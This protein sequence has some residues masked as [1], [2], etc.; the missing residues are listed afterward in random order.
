MVAVRTG[1]PSPMQPMGSFPPMALPAGQTPV[2][3]SV[4]PMPLAGFP[5][6]PV[7]PPMAQQ[8]SNAPRRRRFGDSLEGMLG[9]NMF[10]PQQQMVAPG[11][12]MMRTPMPRP[13][14]MGGAVQYF[15]NGG[16]ANQ[17]A[18]QSMLSAGIGNIGGKAITSGAQSVQD[19]FADASSRRRRRRRKRKARQE[20]ERLAAEQAALAAQQ[21]N[22]NI[23][24]PMESAIGYF[25]SSAASSPAAPPPPSTDITPEVFIPEVDAASTAE[26]FMNIEKP[27]RILDRQ[28]ALFPDL[29]DDDPAFTQG[30]VPSEVSPGPQFT[31]QNIGGIGLGD[32]VDITNPDYP[33]PM[34]PIP[35]NYYGGSTFEESEGMKSRILYPPSYQQRLSQTGEPS[36]EELEA[37]RA[38][39]YKLPQGPFGGPISP[40]RDD[41]FEQNTFAPEFPALPGNRG[42]TPSGT[43][44]APEA[45]T[46]F[47]ITPEEQ[48]IMSGMSAVPDAGRKIIGEKDDSFAES[49]FDAKPTIEEQTIID[50]MSAVPG[51]GQKIT[52]PKASTG[53]SDRDDKSD[54]RLKLIPK[55]EDGKPVVD[56]DVL[57]NTGLLEIYLE[58]LAN[59]DERLNRTPQVPGAAQTQL[60]TDAFNMASKDPNFLEQVIGKVVKNLTFGTFDPN[61]RNRAQAQAILDAYKE[62]GTFAYDSEKDAL[63]LSDTPE[64]RAN[65][66]KLQEMSAGDGQEIGTIGVYDAE[67]NIVGNNNTYVNTKDGVVVENIFDKLSS[68]DDG[69]SD[70]GTDT[71]VDTGH[72]VNDDGNI[73]CNT[74]GYV[75]NPETKI[76]EPAKEVETTPGSGIGTS[77][78]GESF[79]E[80]LKRVVVAAPDVA[81]IS[82]N[83]RPM[84][85]GG[86]VGLNRAADNFLKALAG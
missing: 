19:S 10:A 74:E 2:P 33:N 29:R 28:A 47:G 67:G 8:G 36:E 63:D 75:Y 6:P 84:Q 22:P 70:T 12:P 5:P 77:T 86:M 23:A 9:R 60:L 66:E 65:F 31:Y 44:I 14:A 73:V 43:Q 4:P 85:E 16:N 49:M 40:P 3:A 59:P 17:Q 30:I 69:G 25:G 24:G 7:K 35:N 61:E 18:A 76:C 62:T 72:T 42:F 78:S 82:A 26:G 13:M 11:M 57:R 51:A 50:G 34:A 45:A 54:P 71:G 52:P 56:L 46:T 53:G 48:G 81:P 32:N 41:T 38:S 39:D 37:F 15:A 27:D 1:F 68:G 20:A 58:N 80:V 21:N 55:G 83:V 64:G 79:D